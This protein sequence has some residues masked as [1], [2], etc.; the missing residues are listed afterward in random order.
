MTWENYLELSEKTLSQEFYV[1]KKDELLLHAV[2]GIITEL[3]ELSDWNGDDV[4]KKEEVADV[5]WYMAI[6]DR[7]LNLNLD[8][9]ITEPIITGHF[10]NDSIL[11][12]CYKLTSLQ[13]DFLK[14]KIY[15]NKEIDI[16]QFSKITIQL[17]NKIKFFSKMNKIDIPNILDTNISKLKARYGDKFTS[18]KAINRDLKTERNI[19][20]SG[21]K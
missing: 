3:E 14:K 6:L 12:S 10:L 18:E 20:E 15:Y 21:D 13:L 8:I 7:E 9:E 16:D 17:H 11:L 1:T 4:N 2:M 19:L 5:L